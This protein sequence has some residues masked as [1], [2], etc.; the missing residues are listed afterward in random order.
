MTYGAR[1]DHLDPAAPLSARPAG[2]VGILFMCYQASIYDQFEEV[3]A[4]WVNDVWFP[5]DLQPAGK[6]PLLHAG[7]R[8]TFACPTQWNSA[9]RTEHQLEK[10]ITLKGGDYFF[11]PGISLLRNLPD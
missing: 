11:V 8:S 7:E 5:Q 1:M 6:D 3:Q 2:G 9:A 4:K 10:L